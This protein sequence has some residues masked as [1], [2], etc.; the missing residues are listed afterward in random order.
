MKQSVIVVRENSSERLDFANLILSVR[1]TYGSKSEVVVGCPGLPNVVDEVKIGDAILF[2][3]YNDGVFEFRALSMDAHQI[4]LLISQI[5]PR[6]GIVGGFVDDDQSNTPFTSMELDKVAASIKHLQDDI[7]QIQNVTPEQL[8]LI[9][10][11]L[12]D[13]QDASQ[14]LGRKDWINYV[15]GTLTT[16]C[17]SA[18]FAPETSK[19]LFK[20]VDSAFRWLF[21]NAL[22]L[23]S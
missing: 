11:K 21:D 2:E 3:T 8:K 17:V 12:K 5:S 4:Q 6:L 13:M 22:I 10:R 9:D 15:A 19:A 23:L 20:A 14:R 18:A 16:M 7:K 1:T